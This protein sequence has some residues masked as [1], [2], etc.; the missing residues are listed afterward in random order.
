MVGH[1][2]LT[3]PLCEHEINATLI[4]KRSSQIAWIAWLSHG[5]ASHAFLHKKLAAYPQIPTRCHLHGWRSRGCSRGV[6]RSSA[7]V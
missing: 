1:E 4:L 7:I 5:C 2:K 6:A 3:P